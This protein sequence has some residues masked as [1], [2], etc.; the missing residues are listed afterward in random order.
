M[1]ITGLVK[2]P[3]K[4]KMKGIDLGQI[5]DSLASEFSSRDDSFKM[6]RFFKAS[7]APKVE[8]VIAAKADRAPAWLVKLVFG[9]DKSANEKGDKNKDDNDAKDVAEKAKA[10]G[11]EAWAK[12]WRAGKQNRRE[13]RRGRKR[14]GQV[15]KI[16]GKR[17]VGESVAGR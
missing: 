7:G 16:E 4:E 14:G 15:G 13:K 10:K 12:A 17:G 8:N 2:N 1:T 6:D 5:K 3:D 9:A 11:K